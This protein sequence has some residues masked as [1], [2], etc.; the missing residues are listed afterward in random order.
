MKVRR[1]HPACLCFDL[2]L[3]VLRCMTARADVAKCCFSPTFSC[4]CDD[5]TL[6]G[7]L[8]AVAQVDAAETPA[9]KS[10]E[11]LSDAV[12]ALKIVDKDESEGFLCCGCCSAFCLTRSRPPRPCCVAST[13]CSQA[14]ASDL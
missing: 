9:D 12:A 8:R 11:E 7:R 5:M 2:I 6:F 10:V 13:P 1:V 14:L 3:H 4:L